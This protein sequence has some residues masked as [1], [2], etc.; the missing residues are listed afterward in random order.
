MDNHKF[1]RAVSAVVSAWF[2]HGP[3]EAAAERARQ[4]LPLTP[5]VARML[6]REL[7][8]RILLSHHIAAQ[9]YA[10]GRSGGKFGAYD[11]EL[12]KLCECSIQ[13]VRL[14][15][16]HVR[17]NSRITSAWH[18]VRKRRREIEAEIG[19]RDAKAGGQGSAGCDA[20]D[21]QSLE[22][23]ILGSPRSAAR[24]ARQVIV[25]RREVEPLQTGSRDHQARVDLSG[26]LAKP[27]QVGGIL[28]EHEIDEIYSQLYVESPWHASA[29]EWMWHRHHET[30]DDPERTFCL[31]PALIVGPP[32]CGKTH[33]ATRLGELT[34][35]PSARV[36]MSNV[37]E[38]WSL[39]GGAFG[40]ANA[41]PG[42]PVQLIAQR[43]YANPLIVL[44]EVEK[45]GRSH[46]GDPLNAILPLLQRETARTFRCPYL[47]AEVDLSHVTWLLMGNCLGRLPA[48]LRDRLTVHHVGHPT[49]QQMRG[50]ATRLFAEDVVDQEVIDTAIREIERGR[51]S[52]RGLHRL[53]E[54]FRR[55]TSRP[56]LH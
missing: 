33:L 14:E 31:P 49:E 17:N 8:G 47:E 12:Q 2:R 7:R 27:K 45:A 51:L 44:D 5:R 9:Q 28:T 34:G 10:L 1:R 4:G 11:R 35:V 38:P 56:I 42:L 30:L 46:H 40:W 6:D 41:Q 19:Q 55:I 15:L 25:H 24:P 37:L 29:I 22:D 52:L 43:G 36:D 48:P 54:E 53:A 23:F 32:G 21:E 39:T 50:L 18:Y 26:S 20:P 13:D 3:F 16:N